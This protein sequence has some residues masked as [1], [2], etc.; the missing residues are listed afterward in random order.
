VRFTPQYWKRTYRLEPGDIVEDPAPAAAG[1]DPS[2]A[3]EEIAKALATGG[4]QVASAWVDQ[5]AAL[6]RQNLAP[7][8]FED[9]LLELFGHLP[10]DQLGE[11]MALAFELAHLQGRD[12]A[13]TE[14]G[15]A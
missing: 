1:V 2:F 11:V 10:V 12:A 9:A 7:Q 3:E 14:N 5:V 6:G 8:A 13:R 15:G 4:D